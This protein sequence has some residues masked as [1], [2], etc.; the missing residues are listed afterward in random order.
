MRI[1][2][3]ITSLRI[4]G[5]EKLLTDMLRPVSEGGAVMELLVFDGVRTAFYEELER[6]GVR[7]HSLGRDCSVYNP[8]FVLRLIPFLRR[9][10]VVH[11]HNTACQLF[12]AM[13]NMFVG[14]RIMTTEHNTSNRRRGKWY[15]RWIDRWMYSRY[16]RIV[17]ISE[18]TRE[19]LLEQLGEGDWPVTVIH[20]GIDVRK[21]SDA[22]PMVA[23]T[24]GRHVVV[25]VAA[26]RAQKDQD[27]VVRAMMH[28]PAD[29]YEL[30][31]VG[32][33]DERIGVVKRLT[34]D[35]GLEERVRFLGVR[36]DVALILKAADVVVLSSHWEGLSLSSVE[37]MASGRPFVASDV[38]GLRD[39]VGGYGVLFPQ[40]DDVALA[41]E[42]RRL[43][44][45]GTWAAEVAER[46]QERAR[47]FDIERMAREYEALL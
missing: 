13:A 3:V 36:T 46:C 32:G 47:E 37:G 12:V 45:D 40:G 38:D 33:D 31:L 27:T 34:E 19:N 15:W 22:E 11:T 2:H 5:A 30:W 18:K 39:I 41:G 1:L 42:I 43:C 25:M 10:D 24:N 7:I 44:E 4:G 16:E 29:E 26:F 9:Y 14:T 20:N 21:F 17:C 35:L 23:D 6:K 8:L 28:L